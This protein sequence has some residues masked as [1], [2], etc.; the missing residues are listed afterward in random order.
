MPAISRYVDCEY[1]RWRSRYRNA[2]QQ[3]DNLPAVFSEV[4]SISRSEVDLA[5]IH[6]AP[7]SLDIGKVSLLQPI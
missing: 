2:C 6:P 1:S 4:D 5:L 3:D 7:D